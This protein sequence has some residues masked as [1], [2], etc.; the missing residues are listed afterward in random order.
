MLKDTDNVPKG[1]VIVSAIIV[2]LLALGAKMQNTFMQ[3]FDQL[4]SSIVQGTMF[5]FL[6]PIMRL[7]TMIADTKLGLIYAII[8]AVYLWFKDRQRGCT[9]GLYKICPWAPP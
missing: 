9:S 6:E 1:Y 3:F 2:V 8:I 5:S 7:I 4:F